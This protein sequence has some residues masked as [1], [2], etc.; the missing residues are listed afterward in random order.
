M[1]DEA[2]G[3]TVPQEALGGPCT[4]PLLRIQASP[5]ASSLNMDRPGSWAEHL[6]KGFLRGFPYLCAL[7]KGPNPQA[8][9]K[10]EPNIAGLAH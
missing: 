6:A 1:T 10:K 7:R 4:A 2:Q 5:S 8:Q 3:F 9:A